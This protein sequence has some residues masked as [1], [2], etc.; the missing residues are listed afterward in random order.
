M[1]RTLAILA[2]AGL[3]LGGCA[4]LDRMGKP[5]TDYDGPDK[6]G[7]PPH[8]AK[9]QDPPKGDHP[10]TPSPSEKDANETCRGL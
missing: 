7:P 3:A 5:A 2:A 8:C 1:K 10:S 9:P 4:D 6:S